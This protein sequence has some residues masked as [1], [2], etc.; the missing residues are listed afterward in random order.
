MISMAGEAEGRPSPY[1]GGSTL[2]GQAKDHKAGAA[3]KGLQ[4]RRGSVETGDG[5][6]TKGCL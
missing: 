2:D 1:L 6:M 4:H 3:K 5:N